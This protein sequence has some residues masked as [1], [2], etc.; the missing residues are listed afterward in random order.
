MSLIFIIIKF[1]NKGTQRN[2]IGM[3]KRNKQAIVCKILRPE[4]VPVP[5]LMLPTQ[6]GERAPA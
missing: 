3:K 4:T 5:A 1:A 2:D 6:R